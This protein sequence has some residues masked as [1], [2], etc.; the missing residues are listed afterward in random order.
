MFLSELHIKTIIYNI[1]CGL[2]Y[3][4]S[5]RVIHRDIKPAN[6]LI[7]EDC[8]IKICDFGLSRSIAGMESSKSVLVEEYNKQIS[9]ELEGDFPEKDDGDELEPLFFG[10]KPNSMINNEITSE[11]SP[12]KEPIL[13]KWNSGDLLFKNV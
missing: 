12:L 9:K 13:Q 10:S 7:N 1:L 6:I 2:K 4:H 11:N 3:M 5:A 8:T